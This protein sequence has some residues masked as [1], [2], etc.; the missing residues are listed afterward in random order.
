[1]NIC[2]Y[3]VELYLIFVVFL[4]KYVAAER[5]YVRACTLIFAFDNCTASKVATVTLHCHAVPYIIHNI[6]VKLNRQFSGT[7]N[8]FAKLR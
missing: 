6:S 2:T 1:M 8:Y 5:S 3:F 7:T 4:E